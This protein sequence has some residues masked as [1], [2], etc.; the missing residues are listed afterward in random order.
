MG[1]L[2]RKVDIDVEWLSKYINYNQRYFKLHGQGSSQLNLSK[3]D[4]LN[5][6]VLIPCLKEQTKIAKVL[7]EIDIKIEKEQE[8]LEGLNNY[9]KGLL[10][11]MF[12]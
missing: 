3:A 9:K 12:I 10:Q 6:K 11:Q 7:W 4:I 8:K 1:A 2:R 5:F